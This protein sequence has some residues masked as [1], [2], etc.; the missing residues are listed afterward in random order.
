MQPSTLAN[1]QPELLAQCSRRHVPKREGIG[2]SE[3]LAQCRRHG[4]SP[5]RQFKPEWEEGVGGQWRGPRV[6]VSAG[7]GVASGA[8]SKRLPT[9][10]R[11]LMP[12]K[13]KAARKQ[14]WYSKAGGK[15]SGKPG[16]KRK[17]DGKGD[18]DP[19]PAKKRTDDVTCFNCGETGH[20]KNRCKKP[21]QITN[22]DAEADE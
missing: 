9:R 5:D 2:Q 11:S 12:A 13:S 3:L 21:L 10:R 6:L 8:T 18:A 4:N 22:G 19:K 15:A 20:Y 14:V 17:R 7:V 1:G 16:G